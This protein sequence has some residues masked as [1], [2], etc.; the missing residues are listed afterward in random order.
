MENKIKK[1]I[2][3]FFK[4]FSKKDKYL[5]LHLLNQL[6]ENGVTPVLSSA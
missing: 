3:K 5:D 2:Q 6:K 4:R 1:T